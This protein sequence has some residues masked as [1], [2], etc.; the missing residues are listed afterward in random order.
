MADARNQRLPLSST[1]A[2]SALPDYW[3]KK[4]PQSGWNFPLAG[5]DNSRHGDGLLSMD[6][7]SYYAQSGAKPYAPQVGWIEQQMYEAYAQY[8]NANYTGNRAPVHIGHHFSQWNG[9]AYWRAFQRFAKAVCGK[10]EVK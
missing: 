8:F 9:G 5:I 10:L 3:P 2:V 4:L 1:I 7:N 6:Y